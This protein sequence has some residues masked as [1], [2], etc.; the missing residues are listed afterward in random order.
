MKI[1]LHNHFIQYWCFYVLLL[2]FNTQYLVGISTAYKPKQDET[3]VNRIYDIA[4]YIY[5]PSNNESMFFVI[6]IIGSYNTEDFA[7]NFY[8]QLDHKK[9]KDRPIIVEE[10]ELASDISNPHI[11]VIGDVDNITLKEVEKRIA[12]KPI[13]TVANSNSLKA[14]FIDVHFVED[15]NNAKFTLNEPELDRRGFDVDKRLIEL[16]R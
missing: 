13:L 14:N 8:N 16:L 12:D 2:L 7:S 4:K 6:G 15:N 11:L 1:F 3:K 9:I 5:W 10:Y